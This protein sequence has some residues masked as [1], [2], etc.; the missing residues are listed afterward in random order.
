MSILCSE[1]QKKD[2]RNHKKHCGKI[3]VSKKL[4][5]TAQ[6]PFWAYPDFPDHARQLRT[7]PDGNVSWSSFG[8][9]NPNIQHKYSP[10]LWRQVSL[11]TADR[12]ADYFLFDVDDRPVRFVLHD[13]SMKMTF[14]DFRGE[15]LSDD[16]GHGGNM[17]L[18]LAEYLIKV[19]AQ[20]P[21]LSREMILAQLERE[22]GGGVATKVAEWEKLAA[23]NGESGSTFLEVQSRSMKQALPM[24]MGR[25][26]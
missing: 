6:D 17:L 23:K 1:C 13:P 16:E 12:D 18:A 11:I 15:I 14:R 9:G 8:F 26:R 20:K 4:P 7:T 3:K 5:G 25:I 22:Y 21:G 24:L 2:W 19:M 10:A